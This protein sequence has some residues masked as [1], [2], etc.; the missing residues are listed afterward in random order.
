MESL[1]RSPSN[2]TVPVFVPAIG[3]VHGFQMKR[4]VATFVPKNGIKYNSRG[5]VYSLIFS[6]SGDLSFR[7]GFLKVMSL[8]SIFYGRYACTP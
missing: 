1:R 7:F 6:E 5:H 4:V 8:S 3:L 2:K